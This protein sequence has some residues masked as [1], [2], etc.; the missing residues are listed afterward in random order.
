M[1][2]TTTRGCPA[3]GACSA[4]MA[5]ERIAFLEAECKRLLVDAVRLQIERDEVRL[6]LR[7]AREESNARYREAAA[8]ADKLYDRARVCT[9]IGCLRFTKG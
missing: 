2:D 6:A 7:S 3:A 8:L 1:T 4:C 9:E 5:A